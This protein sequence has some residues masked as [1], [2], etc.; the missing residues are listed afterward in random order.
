MAIHVALLRAVNVG[1]SGRLEMR[2]LRA[3]C[4]A[5]GFS[6]VRTYIASGNV[7]FTAEASETDVRTRLAAALEASLGAAV[8]VVVRSGAEL[9]EVLAANPFADEAP[10]RVHVIFLDA[11]TPSDALAGL[12][13]Q[14]DEQI[15][16]GLREIYVRYPR[17]Q[18]VSRLRL[19]AARGGTARNLGTI[20]RLAEMA[21]A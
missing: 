12:T 16:A 5:C 14:S 21:S 13:G 2:A 18:G 1:G 10:N 9:A 8:G 7:L 19:P 3:V 17:G 6:A 4:E 15:V 11:P 20:A